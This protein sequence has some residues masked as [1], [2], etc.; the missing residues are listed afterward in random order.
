M[1]WAGEKPAAVQLC[2]RLP[3]GVA[4][5]TTTPDAHH[6]PL[7]NGVFLLDLDVQLD[8]VAPERLTKVSGD[9]LRAW[10]PARRLERVRFDFSRLPLNLLAAERVVSLQLKPDLWF[11]GGSVVVER[12]PWASLASSLDGEVKLERS[13]TRGPEPLQDW[14]RLPSGTYVLSYTPPEPPRGTCPVTLSVAAM[15]TVRADRNAA[16][17]RELVERY[18][19]ELLPVAVKRQKLT[20]ASFEA[21]Q[22]RVTLVDGVFHR[23]L[24]PEFSR[25]RLPEKEPRTVLRV[26]GVEAEFTSGMRVEIAAGQQLELA[27][28]A[29]QAVR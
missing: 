16:V 23:P 27:H 13:S 10:L 20:C 6:R 5:F 9:C 1:A 11:D 29:P 18:R 2:L 7:G 24:E 8:G 22:A 19:Q 12:A 26:D 17:F 21:L 15:G 3:D 28:V 4:L 25:V 14:Q